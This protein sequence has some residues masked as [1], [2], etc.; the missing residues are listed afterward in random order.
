MG[1]CILD[2]VRSGLDL[3]SSRKAG[4]HGTQQLFAIQFGQ[5]VEKI[6]VRCPRRHSHHVP[7]QLRRTR[8]PTHRVWAYALNTINQAFS[9]SVTQQAANNIAKLAWIGDWNIDKL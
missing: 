3:P 4:S 6:V 5:S 2:V 8:W 1:G 9:L 7:I